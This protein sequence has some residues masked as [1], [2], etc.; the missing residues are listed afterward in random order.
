MAITKS[1]DNRTGITY[2][3]SSE[4]YWD[5][6]KKAPRNRKKLIGKID[7][8]TGEIVPTGKRGR[9][10]K[11]EAAGDAGNDYR[12]LYESAKEELRQKEQM[13]LELNARLS[14]VKKELKQAAQTLE[15]IRALIG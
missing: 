15:K 9:K 13:I 7:E 4:S 1:K 11:A 12:K 8:A 14:E 6:E 5:K 10:P 2:V 3:Y